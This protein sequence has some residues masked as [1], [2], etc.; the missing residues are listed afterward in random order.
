MNYSQE[1]PSHNVTVITELITP[2]TTADGAAG[3][4]DFVT[5]GQLANQVDNQW[6]EGG[7]KKSAKKPRQLFEKRLR[8][9]R[10]GVK[11]SLFANHVVCWLPPIPSVWKKLNQS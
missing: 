8:G 2:N 7:L 10:E 3:W 1:N 6:G 5:G 4:T 9:G 11:K